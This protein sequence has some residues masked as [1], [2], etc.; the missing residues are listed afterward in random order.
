T[1]TVSRIVSM[2]K[3]VTMVSHD[4]D[5]AIKLGHKIAIFRADK[6]LQI[7]HPDTLLAHPADELVSNFVGPDSTLKCLL[8]VKAEAR[9]KAAAKA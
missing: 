9:K 8:L 6:L 7:D 5:E 4:I 3:T 2:I 1:T